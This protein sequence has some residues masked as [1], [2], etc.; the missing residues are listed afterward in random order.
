MLFGGLWEKWD[1]EVGP[2]ETGA[3]LTTDANDLTKEV[4]NR[5]PVI[6]AGDDAVAW[7]EPGDDK[8]SGR[9]RRT[10]RHTMRSIRQW[11]T[12]ATIRPIASR[13]SFYE[14]RPSNRRDHHG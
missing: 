14:P 3:I 10:G 2:V 13:P 4:H 11:E 9:F 1:D 7:V 5:M 6:L 8:G 12:S